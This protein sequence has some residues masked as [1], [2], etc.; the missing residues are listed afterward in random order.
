MR[1]RAVRHRL[2]WRQRDVAARA[3]ISQDQVSRIEPGR[4]DQ[5]PLRIVRSVFAVPEMSLAL[6]ARWRGGELDRIVD[7]RHAA[8]VGHLAGRLEAA[9]WVVQVEVSFSV[10]G[11]RGSIDL[12]AWHAGT[13]AHLLSEVRSSLNAVEETLR[14]HDVKVRL[15][16]AIARERFG[17]SATTCS[18]LPVMPDESTA[19]RRVAALGVVLARSYPIRGPAA[20]SWI[21]APTGEA[22]LLLFLSPA[23]GGR[24]GHSAGARHRIR[25]SRKAAL[26]DRSRAGRVPR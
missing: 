15:G 21:R 2:G 19:R 12:L 16:P 17:W 10:C 26:D 3:G 23:R 6:E 8:L 5:M 14:R 11:E 22:A 13:R 7:H 24:R 4:I 1:V 25:A 20:R 18:R 9:G